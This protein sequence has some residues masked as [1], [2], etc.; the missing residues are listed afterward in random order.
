MGKIHSHGK[1][2]LQL[3]VDTIEELQVIIDHFNMFPLKSVVKRT[4]LAVSGRTF[5]YSASQI[6]RLFFISRMFQYN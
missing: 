2:S 3:R 6:R 1:N 4:T 5:H